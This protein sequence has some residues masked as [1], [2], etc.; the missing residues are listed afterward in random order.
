MKRKNVIQKMIAIIMTMSMIVAM[1]PAIAFAETEECTHPKESVVPVSATESTCTEAGYTEG[2]YCNDCG[3]YISGHEKLPLASHTYDTTVVEPTYTKG[4]YTLYVCSICGH[5]ETSDPTAMKKLNKP[6]VTV[7]PVSSTSL[8]VSWKEVNGATGYY[9][10]KA[11]SKTGK[12][13]KV[14]TVK[15]TSALVSSLT[16]GKTYYFMVK[17][18]NSAQTTDYSTVKSG[19]VRIAAP[20]MNKT[21]YSTYNSI[22]FS[23][24]KVSG[25]SGYYIYRRSIGGSWKKIATVKGNTT[26]KYT[27]KSVTGPYEYS[28]VSYK[29]SNGKTYTS[30]KSDPIRTRTLRATSSVKVKQYN[31]EFAAKLSWYKVTGATKYQYSYKIGTGSWKAPVSVTGTSVVKSQTH[32]LWYDY[33]VRPVYTYNGVTTYGPYKELPNEYIIYYTPSYTVWMS[34]DSDSSTSLVGMYITNTGSAKM[35][36]YSKN[37]RLIDKDYTRYNRSLKI[38]DEAALDR[39]YISYKSYIDIPAGQSSWVWFSVEGRNTWY[40]RWSRVKFEFSYDNIRYS[41][42]SSAYYGNYYSEL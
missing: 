8:R 25:V 18:Y 11:T 4:G 29:V 13:T 12:Y 10:Y 27:N 28:V 1:T 31:D 7:T 41:G 26:F 32:G 40:D 35:R 5:E 42:T 30:L 37:A 24:K 19:T 15:G 20:V 16:L 21:A 3:Q 6:V 17:A 9:V 2:Q 38:L 34:E 39:G 36:V 14:A 33:K 23:W 22:Q